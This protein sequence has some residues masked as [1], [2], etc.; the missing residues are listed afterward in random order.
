MNR[1]SAPPRVKA[2]A[3]SCAERAGVSLE[4][5]L[6]GRERRN[7]RTTRD[8]AVCALRDEALARS[9]ELRDEKGDRVF[10]LPRLGAIFGA[11]DHSSVFAAINRYVAAHGRPTPL[12]RWID[13]DETRL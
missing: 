6:T 8:R 10:S 11:R 7:G 5:M 13:H 12:Y 4:E 1:I 9:Y 3:V 2:V